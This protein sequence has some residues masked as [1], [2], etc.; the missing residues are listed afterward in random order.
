[1]NVVDVELVE[2]LDFAILLEECTAQ[3]NE[4]QILLRRLNCIHFDVYS[5]GSP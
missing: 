4:A 3:M 5:N 2:E 1:M